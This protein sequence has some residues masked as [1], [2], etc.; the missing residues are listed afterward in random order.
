MWRIVVTITIGLLGI[1]AGVAIAQQ[2]QKPSTPPRANHSAQPNQAQPQI[3]QVPH[4]ER[5]MILI[6]STLLAVNQANLTGN[7]SVLRELGTPEFQETNNPARLADI[8]RKLRERAIDLGPIAVLD[9][10]LT[11]QP[12]IDG[13]GQ[14][15]LTGYFPSRPEQV[16]FDLAFYLRN[17]RWRLDG[18]ALNTTPSQAAAA[19]GPAPQPQVSSTANNQPAPPPPSKPKKAS[20]PSQNTSTAAKRVPDVRERVEKLEVAPPP[21]ANTQTKPK[22]GGWNP[23]SPD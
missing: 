4:P 14:L 2:T 11:R 3:P 1:F 19:P 5:L 22:S 6:R 7:Y 21:K 16:N 17:G 13:N 23:F 18:I 10:K 12:S 9:A 8:F 15:R 20:P